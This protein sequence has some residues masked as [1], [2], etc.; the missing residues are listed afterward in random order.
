MLIKKKKERFNNLND[1]CI[2]KSMIVCEL[3]KNCNSKF[4][5][6]FHN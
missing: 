6:A 1:Q 2:N 5:N 3:N 4:G